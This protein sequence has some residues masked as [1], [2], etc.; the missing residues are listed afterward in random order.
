MNKSKSQNS[1][2]LI[3]AL[4]AI[5]LLLF[6]P[7]W[8]NAYLTP[9]YLIIH[10]LL[11]FGLTKINDFKSALKPVTFGL[12]TCGTPLGLMLIQDIISIPIYLVLNGN[13]SEILFVTGF[14]FLV[15]LVDFVLTY[16]IYKFWWTRKQT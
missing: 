5:G 3:I 6:L 7:I 14:T 15:C 8:M 13:L 2:G 1:T 4:V 16:F 9:I 10:G 11:V 12:I